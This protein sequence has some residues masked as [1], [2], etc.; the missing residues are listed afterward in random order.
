MFKDENR[1]YSLSKLSV[2]LASVLIGISFASS[3]TGSSVKADTVNGGNNGAQAVV[4]S[5]AK[6]NDIIT[7][8]SNAVI[9]FDFF[10]AFPFYLLCWCLKFSKNVRGLCL[11][12]SILSPHSV[13]R[14]P[15]GVLKAIIV[16]TRKD[17]RHD[18]IEAEF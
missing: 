6:S 17:I 18:W 13:L 12:I 10:I 7:K 14:I 1:H 5:P 16:Y 15:I 2:G 8:D 3:T 11:P 4:Q 9:V